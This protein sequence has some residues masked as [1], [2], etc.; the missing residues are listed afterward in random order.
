[1]RCVSIYIHIDMYLLRLVGPTPYLERLERS[2]DYINIKGPSV[3]K[4]SNNI[5]YGLA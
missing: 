2:D 3:I 1:M 5:F 4:N